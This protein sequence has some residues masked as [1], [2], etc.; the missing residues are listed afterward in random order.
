MAG[1]DTRSAKYPTKLRLPEGMPIDYFDPDFYNALQPRLRDR[2]TNTKVAMLPDVEHSFLRSA[3]EKLDDKQFNAKYGNDIIAKY[4][5]VE[6]GELEDFEGEEEW[7]ADDD[8]DAEMSSG[9]EEDVEEDGYDIGGDVDMIA[10]EESL[11]AQL[12]VGIV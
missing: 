6:E 2:I 12:S 11:A 3:D 4:Q 9:D 1:E 7:L 8:E 10:R 5:L